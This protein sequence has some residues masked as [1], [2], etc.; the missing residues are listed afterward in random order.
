MA[1]WFF[2]GTVGTPLP[3]MASV[4]PIWA[5]LSHAQPLDGAFFFLLFFVLIPC[6]HMLTISV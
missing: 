4:C 6:F 5:V 1:T 2:V 3:W